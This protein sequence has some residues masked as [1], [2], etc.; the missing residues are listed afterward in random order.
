MLRAMSRLLA[1]FV[2][3]SLLATTIG[4][5]DPAPAKGASDL[6]YASLEG[7]ISFTKPWFDTPKGPTAHIGIRVD[8][9]SIGRCDKDVRDTRTVCVE[10][11]LS[12][13]WHVINIDFSYAGGSARDYVHA[14][15]RLLVGAKEEIAFD[16]SKSATSDQSKYVTRTTKSN[17]LV[18]CEKELHALA[19][20]RSCTTAELSKVL[21]EVGRAAEACAAAAP[22]EEARARGALSFVFDN[23]F[24]LGADHCFKS[25]ELLRVPRV[26]KATAGDPRW[27][28]AGTLKHGSWGWA[29]DVLPPGYEQSAG[30]V[31]AR[32]D[33][34]KTALPVV[35]TRLGVVEDFMT[36]YVSEKKPQQA[37]DKALRDPFDL[38]PRKPNG[39]RLHILLHG[40]DFARAGD[41]K[42]PFYDEKFAEYVAKSIHD[43][44]IHCGQ[45]AE[46]S[47]ATGYLYADKKITKAEWASVQQL[48]KRTPPDASV[49]GACANVVVDTITRDVP[50][51]E[52]LRWLTAWDCGAAR[53]PKLRGAAARAYLSSS[54][55]EVRARLRKLV[56]AEFAAC[57]GPED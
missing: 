40:P 54:N 29:H 57:L 19:G 36:A 11:E 35:I 25:S 16:L 26:V 23:L 22:E 46:A 5:D 44:P 12:P 8:G 1:I 28:P 7:H 2:A 14:E 56:R 53:G 43:G 41:I 27:W 10:H 24:M 31:K 37:I 50:Q 4:C 51:I 18:P 6:R 20:A 48:V 17:E 38:D 33:V 21:S 15:D 52:R 9:A 32:L 39:H 49:A 47:L 3:G 34:A 45:N 42:T 55:T 30:S 13:G